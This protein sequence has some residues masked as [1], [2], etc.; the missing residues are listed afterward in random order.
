M[1]N[2]WQKKILL[3]D[4]IVGQVSKKDQIMDWFTWCSYMSS[5]RDDTM[6][7]KAFRELLY[8]YQDNLMDAMNFV[9]RCPH[10]RILYTY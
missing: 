7:A 10:V 1:V 9:A 4:S 6:A 2:W 3:T 5:A 8:T